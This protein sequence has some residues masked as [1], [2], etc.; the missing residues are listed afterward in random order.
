MKLSLVLALK[1]L[2]FFLFFLLVLAAC[3]SSVGQ[4]TLEE[5]KG[6]LDPSIQSRSL[7]EANLSILRE[8]SSL[9]LNWSISRD[10]FSY[11]L[12]RSP[13][14]NFDEAQ[15]LATDL[16]VNSFVD[17]SALL[18]QGYFYFLQI[19]DKAACSEPSAPVFAALV[20]FPTHIQA[21]NKDAA[22]TLDWEINLL[23][24]FYKVYRSSSP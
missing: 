4:R 11:S 6:L 20:D 23:V 18:N 19:C 9:V 13:S 22:I 17:D 5:Y 10:D 8:N 12:F 1:K 21:G 7:S 15:V 2:Y 24:D 16:F 14:Y 3:D